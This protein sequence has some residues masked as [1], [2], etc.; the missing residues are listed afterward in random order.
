[1]PP[2]NEAMPFD[3]EGIEVVTKPCAPA[4]PT[5]AGVVVLLVLLLL[6]LIGLIAALG[7]LLV[8]AWVALALALALLHVPQILS[9]L[10]E[11][12]TAPSGATGAKNPG[13]ALPAFPEGVVVALPLVACGR[14]GVGLTL[15]DWKPGG[16]VPHKELP[17]AD[18][19]LLGLVAVASATAETCGSAPI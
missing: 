5:S 4:I 15:G 3:W 17:K 19:L 6:I 13:G 11:P 10:E 1:M 2:H 12:V 14:V 18:V 9:L 7:V 16:G 8:L